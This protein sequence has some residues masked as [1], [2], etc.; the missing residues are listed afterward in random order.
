MAIRNIVK[1]DEDKC[2]GCGICV[3]ACAEGAIQIIDGKA[4]LVSE[5]YCDGLGACLGH[6]P[7][8]AIT[9]EKREAKAFDEAETNRHILVGAGKPELPCGCPGT[10]ARHIERKTTG[11][12]SALP[13]EQSSSALTNWPVQLMLIPTNAPYLKNA[14]LLLAADCVPFS[15]SEF[16]QKLLAG[17]A[18]IIG[19]P[20]LDD[21]NIYVEKLSEILRINKPKSLTVAHMEVPCCKGLIRIAEAAIAGSGVNIAINDITVGINGVI[22]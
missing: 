11:T 15:C 4:R 1:I 18:L 17:K 8:D 21:A 7:Q 19:C 20:K 14:D 10:M 12:S 22:K 6:C 2:N 13:N 16:H 9:I 3:R 5:I